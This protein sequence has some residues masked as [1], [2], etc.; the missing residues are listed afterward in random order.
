MSLHEK[1]IY[2]NEKNEQIEFSALSDFFLIKISG[3]AGVSNVINSTKSRTDGSFYINSTVSDR[4][5]VIQ[6]KLKKNNRDSNRLKLINVL[7]PK[8]KGKLYY[9]N[10]KT[11]TFKYID[12]IIEKSPDPV[13]DF[14]STFQ[15]S[16]IC[17]NPFW[18]DLET[19]KITIAN[20]I[21]DFHF[22]LSIIEKGITMG[23]RQ[24]SLIANV[25]NNGDIETGMIIEFIANGT[26]K[27]PSLFN[28]NSREFL[29]INKTMVPGEKILINTNFGEKK[30]ESNLHG[31]TTNILNYLDIQGGGCSFLKLDIGDNL[32]RY[33]AD[34]NLNNLEVNIYFTPCYLG[35]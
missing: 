1:F 32:F 6:G 13:K 28:V 24:P 19:T 12:C 11:N 7:N 15:I 25:K 26:L 29:K 35:V 17:N 30:I 16:L 8:L 34:E 21:G 31:V 9:S 14:V 33:D 3:I 22:P 18:K 4:N 2:K 5:I 20:W 10:L 23:H 27:N